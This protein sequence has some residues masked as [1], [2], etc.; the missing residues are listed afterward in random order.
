MTALVLLHEVLD[1]TLPLELVDGQG[2]RLKGAPAVRILNRADRAALEWAC[3]LC[4]GDVTALTLAPP[5]TDTILHFA[6]A[7]G[8][9]RAVRVWAPGVE[10]L[11]AAAT[12]RLLAR[13]VERLHPDLVFT[14]DRSL[15]GW[16]GLVP[17]MLA[18]R[19]GWPCLEQA[20]G[21][22]L[23]SGVVIARRRLERGW[24]EE[25]EAPPPTVIAVEA[26]S[27]EPRYISARGRREARAHPVEAWGL[28]HLGVSLVEALA[29]VRSEV[30]SLDWPRP[31]PRKVAL[32]S[33]GLSAAERMRQLMGGGAAPKQAPEG[34]LVEGDPGQ[35]ADRLVQ[36]L[37]ERGFCEKDIGV[38]VDLVL[39][40]SR[41]SRAIS[42]GCRKSCRCRPW[43][44]AA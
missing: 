32:P 38:S 15:P 39:E 16:T 24:Q 43:P 7:R 8:A 6:R 22:T 18:A 31:R 10:R 28:Q 4:P 12:T 23:E 35:I 34:K 2:V 41:A 14:G 1:I 20:V 11:D 40:K 36:F 19:L 13:A 29:W 21:L 30:A 17:A 9:R 27:I 5:E 25:I 42:T 3:R 33:A 37:A 26:G 44:R